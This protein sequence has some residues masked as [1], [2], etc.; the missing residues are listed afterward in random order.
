MSKIGQGLTILG[1]TISD[2][3]DTFS[4]WA[5]R[6]MFSP[7]P[8]ATTLKISFSNLEIPCRPSQLTQPTKT[9]QSRQMIAL[10]S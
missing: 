9:R 10:P 5:A 7:F 6:L 8:F 4:S 2:G 1:Y 3:L